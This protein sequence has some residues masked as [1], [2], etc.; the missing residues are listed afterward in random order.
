[1]KGTRKV[2]NLTVVGCRAY[3]YGILFLLIIVLLIDHARRLLVETFRSLYKRRL[4]IYIG[5]NILYDIR[6]TIAVQI[7]TNFVIV[8]RQRSSDSITTL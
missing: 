2:K 5:C 3:I 8:S 7:Q 6:R 4:S 1:M